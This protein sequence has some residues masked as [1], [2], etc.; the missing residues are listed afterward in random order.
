MLDGELHHPCSPYSLESRKLFRPP[1][2]YFLSDGEGVRRT[3]NSSQKPMGQQAE[4]REVEASWIRHAVL[5]G[6]Q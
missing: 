1:G 3:Y 2:S 5:L 4:G 6:K